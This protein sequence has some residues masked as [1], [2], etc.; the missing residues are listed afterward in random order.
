MKQHYYVIEH[1]SCF[2]RH[3]VC[4]F[5]VPTHL[6][7]VVKL[8]C[9]QPPKSHF[10]NFSNSVCSCF[11]FFPHKSSRLVVKCAVILGDV[12]F[13]TTTVSLAVTRRPGEKGAATAAGTEARGGSKRRKNS[14]FSVSPVE[15]RRDRASFGGEGGELFA[16]TARKLRGL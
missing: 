3:N 4:R 9:V 15:S 13:K 8:V 6:D 16:F 7:H 1:K 2:C 14:P 5:W 12:Y 10:S 11:F